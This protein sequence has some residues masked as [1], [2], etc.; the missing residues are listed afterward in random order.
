MFAGL[1]TFIAASLSIYFIVLPE[2]ERLEGLKIINKDM[3]PQ[4]LLAL[5]L[6][7]FLV[8]VGVYIHIAK[9][10]IVGFIIVL[11]FGG[12]LTLSHAIGFLIG[13]SSHG[14]LLLDILPGFFAFLTIIFAL[15]SIKNTEVKHQ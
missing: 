12:L 9:R 13:T 4:S 1:T 11:I 2:M 15:F 6:P 8:V 5:L 14:H 10:S 7:A 3:L